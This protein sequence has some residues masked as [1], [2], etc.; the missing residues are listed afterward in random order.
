MVSLIKHIIIFFQ[1]FGI[2]FSA[3]IIKGIVED[4]QTG[5]P[6]I[7]ASVFIDESDLGSASDVNG[8]Y[9]IS[10]IRSCSTCTYKLKVLYIGYEEYNIDILVNEN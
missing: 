6:L 9:L 8:A 1:L 3:A 5:S 4:S 7:G 2:L 10:N